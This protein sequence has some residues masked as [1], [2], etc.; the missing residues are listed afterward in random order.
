MNRVNTILNNQKFCK[1]LHRISQMEKHREFCK[2][3]MCHLLDVARIAYIMVLE[4]N[5][6]IKKETIYAAALLHD[7]GKWMQ[8]DNGISHE[9]AS[10]KLAEDILME[11]GFMKEEIQQILNIILSHRKKDPNNLINNIFYS[12]DKISRN[13]FDCKAISKCNWSEKKKNHS[14]KY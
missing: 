8:Y 13:C 3:D 2:H 4:N 1:Y 14:I 6:D 7:I 11:C 5:I 10:A 12:S 9:L